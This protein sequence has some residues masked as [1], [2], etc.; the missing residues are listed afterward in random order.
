MSLHAQGGN[1]AI[2]LFVL[3]NAAEQG[4]PD[5][6]H[7][8]LNTNLIKYSSSRNLIKVFETTFDPALK[9]SVFRKSMLMAAAYGSIRQNIRNENEILFRLMDF[10]NNS[11]HE[12][13]IPIQNN[14]LDEAALTAALL[15]RSTFEGSPLSRLRIETDPSNLSILL[16]GKTE[17]LSPKEL[18]LNPGLHQIEIKG[19][20]IKPY[21]EVVH[22]ASGAT[23]NLFH[24]AEIKYYPTWF[25]LIVAAATTWESALM[26]HVE[27]KNR[28]KNPNRVESAR[29]ARI[30]LTSIATI[31]WTGSGVCF[32]K[33]RKLNK[34]YLR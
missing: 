15:I 16:D 7:I 19:E 13:T 21:S 18:I 34:R 27:G 11:L 5:S 33:N 28:D 29:D 32:W 25:F 31:G 23:D 20:R 6:F 8:H 12:K 3:E 4:F 2:G 30:I 1:R 10:R 14:S 26:Y 17:G 9:D 22:I 24:Q